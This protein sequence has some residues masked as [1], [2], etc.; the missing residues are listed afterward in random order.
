MI[1]TRRWLWCLATLIPAVVAAQDVVKVGVM[2]SQ[3]GPFA[4]FGEQTRR[5]MELYLDEVGGKCGNSKIELIYRDEA[6]GPDKAKALT[7]DL[8]VRDR[9][10]F[11]TGFNLTPTAFA[12]APLVTEA[13]MPTLITVAGAGVITRRSPYIAR[14]SFTLW[15]HA[16]ILGEWAA[17]NGIKEI[18]IAYSDYAAGTDTPVLNVGFF[19]IE[20]AFDPDRG[21]APVTDPFNERALR[22]LSTTFTPGKGSPV[23]L[24]TTLP[25]IT[26]L[27]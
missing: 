17:R 14:V 4:L 25:R 11:L 22:S 10:Q 21:F 16:Y 12:I 2:M 26:C 19:D 7:Q 6:G 27:F 9:V 24:S 13:K 15:Q 5:G 18:V 23:V 8:I 1:D 3:S 20:V